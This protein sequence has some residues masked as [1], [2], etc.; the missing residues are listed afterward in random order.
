MSW[1][2][3]PVFVAKGEERE[4]SLCEVYLDESGGLKAWSQN[5]SVEPAGASA[6]E[7]EADLL[8]MLEDLHRWEPVEFDSLRTGMKL[9]SK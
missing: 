2:Y 7:L 3:L 6:A 8:N 5:R 4:Y 1:H 9:A